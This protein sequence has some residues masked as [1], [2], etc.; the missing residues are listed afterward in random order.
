LRQQIL[1]IPCYIL[2]KHDQQIFSIYHL[3]GT[4][5][6]D[7]EDRLD[8]LHTLNIGFQDQQRMIRKKMLAYGQAVAASLTPRINPSLST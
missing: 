2:T 1:F 8:G 5:L 7:L 6:I 4:F 3:R